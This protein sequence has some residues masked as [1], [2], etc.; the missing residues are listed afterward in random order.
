MYKG[1]KMQ[2]I[3]RDGGEDRVKPVH[4]QQAVMG[5]LLVKKLLQNLECLVLAQELRVIKE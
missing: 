2:V 5:Y 3:I 4:K 1:I